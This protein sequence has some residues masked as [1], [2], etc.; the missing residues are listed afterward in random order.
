MN[1]LQA[2]LLGVVEGITEFL[3]I[4]STFH[5][6]FAAKLLRISQNDFTK[7]FEVFIQSGAVLSIT[8]LYFSNVVK[9]K[10]LT[11]KVIISFLPTAIIGFI[12]YKFI[13]NVLFENQIFMVGI[14]AAVG[15]IFFL[16]EFLI[17]R[18]KINLVKKVSSL[19]Y[20]DALI[21]GLAQTLAIFPGVSRAGAVIVA[22]MLLKYRRDESAYYSFLLSIPTIFAAAFFDLFKMRMLIFNYSNN[23][24]L[25][26]VGFVTALI[27]SYFVVKWF[28][29]FLQKNSLVIFGY[30][31][32]V[33]AIILLLILFR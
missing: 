21:I 28:I 26:L 29:K 2:T 8:L 11:K 20:Q 5:L 32:L 25:L 23:W 6:I 1:I 33:V 15:G 12:L 14:F 18:K 31:R 17:K 27:S 30:Y 19:T 3:P 10:E 7:L 13:K 4:S 9:Y 16:V 24:I 22:M